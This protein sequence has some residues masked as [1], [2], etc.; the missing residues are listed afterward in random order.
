MKI[1][2]IIIL[3]IFF[4]SCSKKDKIN[5]Y[6]N[7]KVTELELVENGFYK[8]SHADTIR[9]EDD[10]DGPIG[11]IFRYEL[12]SNVKPQRQDDGKIYPVPLFKNIALDKQKSEERYSYITNELDNRVITYLF[13]NDILDFKSI[14]VYEIDKNK[15]QIADFTSE[16]AIL[17]YYK[18]QKVPFKQRVGGI[19][20]GKDKIEFP[21]RFRINN[22][23]TGIYIF[24]YPND[25]ELSYQLVTTY[26]NVKENEETVYDFRH[27][28]PDNVERWYNGYTYEYV[29]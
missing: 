25:P 16:K 18:N 23:E 26:E 4:N 3:A 24:R 28:N 17:N 11:T 13:V 19:K 8:Y 29:K 21:Y 14:Y 9:E 12:Y 27:I 15:K 1:S 5:H 10:I 20:Y 2:I 22:Y 7:K 6:L